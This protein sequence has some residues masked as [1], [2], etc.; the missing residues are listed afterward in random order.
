MVAEQTEN[1]EA[2]GEPGSLGKITLRAVLGTV[3]MRGQQLG[4]RF[5]P[6]FAYGDD[7]QS[8]AKKRNWRERFL[9]EREWLCHGRR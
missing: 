3:F 2:P 6:G 7:E 9:A 8:T 4:Y 1:L 5:A